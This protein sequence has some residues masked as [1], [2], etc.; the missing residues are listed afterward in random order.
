MGAPNDANRTITPLEPTGAFLD[1]ADALGI[2][3]DP[4]D[5]ERLGLYLALLLERNKVTNLTAIK[6]PAE[7][8]IRHVLDALTLLPIAAELPDGALVADV[9]SGGGA[10]A[11]PLAIVEPRL[12]FTLIEATGK[13]AEFLRETIA[14]LGLAN[15][16]VRGDRVETLAAHGGDLRGRFDLVTARALGRIAVASE[17]TI[18]LAT[19]GGLVALIKGEKAD[20][21]LAEAKQAL[22]MLCATHIG[23]Q[24]TPTGRI[25]VLEKRRQT[26]RKYPRRPGEPKRAPL[27]LESEQPR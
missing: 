25:V 26:P 20:E 14:A 23:T 22:H 19:V 24:P 4:G 17:L 27:G 2:A 3:F 8:W 1:A 13:K 18:P 6:D 16:E 12:R 5:L 15:C 21:E 10:P 9:G 11:I 7:C